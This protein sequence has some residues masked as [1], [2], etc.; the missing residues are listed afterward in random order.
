MELTKEQFD[1]VNK[2]N[3]NIIVSAGAGSGKTSV[4]SKRVI[5]KLMDGV[6][7]D[8][9]LILTFTNAA[10]LEM[11]ERIRKAIKEIPELK[12]QLNILDSAYIGTFDSFASAIVKKYN[13]LLNIPKDFSI[14]DANLL[15]Y[16]KNVILDNIFNK[17]YSNKNSELLKIITSYCDKDDTNIKNFIITLDNKLNLLI[18]KEKYLDE[19]LDKHFNYQKIDDDI[20]LYEDKIFSI[21]NDI[22][23]NLD[24]FVSMASAKNSEILSNYLEPLFKAKTYDELVNIDLGKFPALRNLESEKIYKDNISTMRTS[25]NDYLHFENKEE[26]KKGILSTYN[27]VSFIVDVEKE[28]NREVTKY[29]YDNSLFEF[30]DI[31]KL[32]IKVVD[33][34][35]DVKEE[36]KNQ[37]KEIMIDEYQDT[38]DLQEKFISL[39]ANNNV[40]MVGDIKQSIYR[41]RNANPKI[42][43]DKYD[44]YKDGLEGIKIDLT[45]NFRSR[46]EIV[47]DINTIFNSLMTDKLGGVNYLEQQMSYGNHKDDYDTYTDNNNGLEILNYH[48]D[49]E[50]KY[51]DNI[52]EAFIIASNIKKKIDNKTIIYD[53]EQ[54][55]FREATY[56]DFAILIDRSTSFEMYKKVFEYFKLPLEIWADEKISDDTS[57]MLLKNILH[58]LIKIKEDEFDQ[59]FEYLMTSILRSPLIEMSDEE[60]FKLFLNDDFK[61]NIV[62]KKCLDL[63]KL[64]DNHS[65]K[66]ISLK[67]IDEFDFYQNIIKLGNVSISMAKIDYFLNNS[68]VFGNIGYNVK[69]FIGFLNDIL[70]DQK[71]IRIGRI[72][73][74]SNA[75]KLMTIH[76]SKGLEYPICYYAGLSVNTNRD[77]ITNSFV[78]D[79][80]YGIIVPADLDGIDNTIY[81]DLYKDNYINEEVSERIRLFYVALTRAREKMIIVTKDL[82]ADAKENLKCFNGFLNYIYP[83]IENKVTEINL[84][85]L[86][87]TRDYNSIKNSNYRE[88]VNSTEKQLVVD[89]L[90]VDNEILETNTYSKHE[91]SLIDEETKKN[92]EFGL[93]VHEVL[94]LLDLKNPNYDN[95][96]PFIKGKI[97]LMLKQD[98]F[99]DINQANIYK[100]YEFMYEEDNNIYHGIIDLMLVY[101]NHVDII[102]YKLKYIDDDAYLKQLNGYKKYI[103]KRLNK[104]TNIYLYSIM[105][106]KINKL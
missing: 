13:Y 52:I 7:I 14:I 92:M 29:K 68:Q 37:F 96:E 41:F 95:I 28:L 72:K 20:K 101:D 58:L 22:K 8:E 70:G 67:I 102:D 56:K 50:I 64:L 9:L 51:K 59:E 79:S 82:K 15:D 81:K 106:N 30:N 4:L 78:F 62:F 46:A 75:I 66:E 26:M 73:D 53:K 42:F 16:Q 27:F 71:D 74:N 93:K 100:E 24:R 87:L 47:K 32:A 12:E 80:N 83:V 85:E 1:A 44:K 21:V 31:A 18:D 48:N 86:G 34:H 105:D 65:I 35:N 23:D 63:S 38:S 2:D 69:D 88:Y 36:I 3:N 91:V 61:N 49:S 60:I 76:S 6:Q 33:D 97:S 103:E 11:K 17:K 43:K 77:E 99:K 84:D 19:Y 25:I 10:A 40:Y 90:I 89:E 39:I 45:S 55:Q 5:R 54:K 94:E 57:F 104:E 98:I